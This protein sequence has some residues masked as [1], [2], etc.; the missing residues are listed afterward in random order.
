[1][2]KRT[3]IS[4]I[5]FSLFCLSCSN[6]SSKERLEK[7]LAL[8]GENRQELT[9]VI[10]H[11]SKNIADSTKL[12]AA[13]FLIE[14]MP[15]HYSVSGKVVDD[16]RQEIEAKH[17]NL[18]E[19]VKKIILS[20]PFRKGDLSKLAVKN[21]DIENIKAEYLIDVIDNAMEKRESCYW[22][23]NTSFEDFCEYVLPYRLEHEPLFPFNDSLMNVWREVNKML[24]YYPDYRADNKDVWD[25]SRIYANQNGVD[26]YL[27]SELFKSL[28][29]NFNYDCFDVAFFDVLDLRSLGITSSVD[30]VPAW[31]NRNG[32]HSWRVILDPKYMNQVGNIH[33]QEVHSMAGKIYRMTYSHNSIPTRN[34]IDS[35]PEFFHSPFYKD[36]TSQYVNTRDVTL[37]LKKGNSKITNDFYLSVFN[38]KEWKPI[39]WAKNEKDKAIFTS[40]QIGIIYL[41]VYYNRKDQ[42]P[43]SNPFLLGYDGNIKTF[44]PDTVNRINMKFVRKYPMSTSKIGW[45]RHMIS[46]FQF[47][48]SNTPN[49]KIIDTIKIETDISPTLGYRTIDIPT[50]KTYRYWRIISDKRLPAI[51]EINFIDAEGNKIGGEI[52]K[53][54]NEK[55]EVKNAFDGDVLSFVKGDS[56]YGLD[57]GIQKRIK[58][59]KYIPRT[60]AN[61]IF[62]GHVYELLYYNQ[63]WV[64]IESKVAENDSIYFQNVPSN[65]VY[66]L[67]NLTE[68]NEERIF[69]CQKNEIIWY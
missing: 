40:M 30:Y 33:G 53:T 28:N 25:F 8:A 14:N 57:F 66:W 26:H 42:E 65:G 67:R 37:D 39:A 24:N 2:K 54:E 31:A 12:R 46:S 13:I 20:V 44:E 48:A 55:T 58:Q 41:P 22:L 18:N 34:G 49:F 10:E 27:F 45:N 56:W 63:G 60:D 32:S 38:N 4:L 36:V 21:H 59:I 3:I 47:E 61:N 29:K 69:I 6:N 7:A 50:E 68:G 11:Y 43:L 52:I 23:A 5:I 35:I 19:N 62:K 64:S 17:N 51:G 16:Y 9:K 1:M 15:G